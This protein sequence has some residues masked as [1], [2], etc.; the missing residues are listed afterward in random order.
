MLLLIAQ[1]FLGGWTSTNYA[2][3]ICPEFPACRDD[4]WVPP[5]DFREGFTLW[6]GL[7]IDYEGGVLDAA[8]RTAIHL[9]HRAGA[10]LVLLVTGVLAFRF[11]RSRDP[12]AVKIAATMLVL[13]LVQLGLGVSNIIMLLPLGIAVA[14]NG[15]AALLLLSVIAA[16]SYAF[17][18]A[19]KK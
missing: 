2:A 4:M 6:R 10:V 5:V 19:E 1:I 7:G 8:G 9:S 3:L 17:A 12:T 13:L 11:Y 16:T 15:V 14:H 18:E